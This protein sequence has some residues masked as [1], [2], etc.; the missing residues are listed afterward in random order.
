M[1]ATTAVLGMSEILLG[2]VI[3]LALL[4][5]VGVVLAILNHVRHEPETTQWWK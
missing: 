1:S 5:G 2:I 4:L 3:A